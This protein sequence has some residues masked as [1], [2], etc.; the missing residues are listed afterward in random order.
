MKIEVTIKVQD[1]YKSVASITAY[2]L[3]EAGDVD[4]L[5]SAASSVQNILKDWNKRREVKK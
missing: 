5:Y 2:D 3:F 1:G 4:Y